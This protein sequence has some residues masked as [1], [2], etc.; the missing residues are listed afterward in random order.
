MKYMENK[1]A[2]TVLALFVSLTAV[3]HAEATGAY[4]DA[5][6][7]RTDLNESGWDNGTSFSVGG[8]YS[9][10]DY[11]AA[12]ARYID[13]GEFDDDTFPV[14]TLSGDAFVV[15]FV[16]SY[17]LTA[18][19]SMFAKLGFFAW[20]AE[21]SEAG[22]GEF[23]SDDGTDITYGAGVTLSFTEQLSSYVQFKRFAFEVSGEDLDLDDIGIGLQ[24]RF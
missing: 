16:A 19:V 11:I 15:D 18:R 21:V 2:L 9:F 13:F 7:G 17:P 4:L 1:L 10:N 8:G 6:V 12:E 24:Y 22:F 3:T 14:W 20:D 5:S 23:A